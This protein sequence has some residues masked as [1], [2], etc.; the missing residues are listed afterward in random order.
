VTPHNLVTKA[1]LGVT[2][3]GT[4]PLVG[5]GSLTQ[6]PS[7]L[8]DTAYIPWI[9]SS[10]QRGVSSSAAV[11]VA[12]PAHVHYREEDISQIYYSTASDDHWVNTMT[13]SNEFTSYGHVAVY[14]CDSMDSFMDCDAGNRTRM[15][16]H[17]RVGVA[18]DDYSGRSVTVWTDHE[19]RTTYPIEN[20]NEVRISVGKANLNTLPHA[21]TIGV[22]SAVAPAV[23]CGGY[24]SAGSFDCIVFYVDIADADHTVKYKRFWNKYENSLN[25]Y[26]IQLDSLT[27][28]VAGIRSSADPAAWHDG[29]RYWVALQEVEAPQ[30]TLVYSSADTYT[31]D[32][33]AFFSGDPVTP[34]ATSHY[35]GD[36]NTLF[37]FQY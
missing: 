16:S 29:E 14:E 17:H 34:T 18:Y 5:R 1:Y 12:G 36:F 15:Q 28:P 9:T 35:S 26:V 6:H 33:E 24:L 37:R 27:A 3:D 4:T 11:S 13:S 8:Y 31:W 7:A 20:A 2:F 22:R 25:R 23:V 21:D 19:S 10:I 30:Y 32:L